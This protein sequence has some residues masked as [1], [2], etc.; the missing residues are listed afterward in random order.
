MTK[1]TRVKWVDEN[2]EEDESRVEL[3]LV[4]QIWT[5]KHV[6]KTT[7]ISTMKK[8]GKKNIMSI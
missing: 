5:N 7:F 2:S 4:G 6:N 8:Y 1:M 3:G